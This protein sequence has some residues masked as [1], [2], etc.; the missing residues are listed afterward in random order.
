MPPAPPQSEPHDPYAVL[1]LRDFRLFL[2]G[3]TTSWVALMMQSTT[4]GW[5]IYERTGEPLA[6]GLVGL[7][8]IIPG[9]LLALPA[10]HAADRY[11]RRKVLLVSQALL[12]L[13][14]AG[15]IASSVWKLP[16]IFMYAC[17]FAVGVSRA[18]MGPAKSALLPR[19]VPREL[20]G[21][22]VTWNSTCFQAC[23][24][25][26][27]GLA[28]GLIWL[29]HGATTAYVVDAVC[30]LAFIASLLSLRVD[31][32]PTGN[33]ESISLA[34]LAAGFRFVWSRKILLAAITLDMF[35][36]LLGGA[37]ALIPVYAKDILR[38]GPAGLGTLNAAPAIGALVMSLALAHR[39]P[40][41]KAGRALL[42][43]VIGFG[44]ATVVFGLS[45]SYALSLAMLFLTGVFDMVSVVVRHTLVQLLAPD[46][47]RGRIS[48]VNSIFIGLSNEL[49][50]FE[51]GFVATLFGSSA[52]LAHGPTVSVVS[53]GIGTILVVLLVWRLWPQLVRFG[54]LDHTGAHEADIPGENPDDNAPRV[55]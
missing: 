25:I 46:D 29:T 34:S 15:L 9:V 20:F 17:L 52:N 6:L 41:E 13:C 40:I 48:A 49:G 21:R 37:V 50:G 45:R 28:G 22:A 27:P 39:R 55:A 3:S 51:S 30:T 43:T 4:I 12:L 10:G 11:D 32:K 33:T 18:L 53:G 2:I 35:A 7:V 16:L 19:L 36:V 8:Q 44:A 1:R 42:W 14:S 38:V 26:G 5:D 47:M 24:F 31:T 54:R 23:A